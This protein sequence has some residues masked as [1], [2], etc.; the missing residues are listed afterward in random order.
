MTSRATVSLQR[1]VLVCKWTLLIC[2]TL[3]TSC[4]SA[5][6]QSR[7]LQLK[8]TMR[9]VAIAALHRAFEHLM[10]K[11]HTESRLHFAVTAHAEL[12]F[13]ELQHVYGRE[14]GLLLIDWTNEYI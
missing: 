11:R 12:R 13:T 2:V 3:D 14:P 9:I 7:L 10:M 5:R 1:C 4:I 8:A 6:C